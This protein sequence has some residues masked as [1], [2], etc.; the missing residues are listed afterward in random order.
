[1]FP[2]VR[3]RRL[4]QSNG[5][6]RMLSTPRPEKLI[7]PTFVVPGEN[8]REP[9]ESM[10]GQARLSVDQLLIDLAPLVETGI[11][12]VLLFGLADTDEK[13]LT[14]ML[15]MHPMEPFKKPFEPLKKPFLNLL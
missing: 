11:G 15:P 12:G 14:E 2:D 10:P 7:W 3:L 8:K 9:I 6:R 13:I 5:I 1:M 4:R